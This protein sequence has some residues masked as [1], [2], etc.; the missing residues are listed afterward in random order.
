L[1]FGYGYVDLVKAIGIRYS[2]KDLEQYFFSKVK[3]RDSKY[4]KLLGYVNKIITKTYQ[5]IKTL[6]KKIKIL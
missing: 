5:E 3:S 1:L 4:K 6:V 2:S